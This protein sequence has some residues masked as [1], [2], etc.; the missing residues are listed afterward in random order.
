M[1]ISCSNVSGRSTKSKK[2]K[3]LFLNFNHNSLT[4]GLLISCHSYDSPK[5][6]VTECC[7]WNRLIVSIIVLLYI[8]IPV[9][10]YPVVLWLINHRCKFS[11]GV[12]NISVTLSADNIV[13]YS[14]HT[15]LLD[16]FTDCQS[17]SC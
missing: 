2:I 7:Y 10:K 5:C 8:R 14:S 15:N 9:T 3:F 11:C 1:E 12:C 4:R 13:Q 6:N 16:V 17:E